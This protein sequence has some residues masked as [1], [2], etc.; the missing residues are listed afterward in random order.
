MADRFG[1]W[2]RPKKR[3]H[4]NEEL[5]E[6][7]TDRELAEMPRVGPQLEV[8]PLNEPFS[9]EIQEN[10]NFTGLSQSATLTNHENFGRYIESVNTITPGEKIVE[11]EAFVSVNDMT[12][13][14][15]CLTCHSLAATTNFIGCDNCPSIAFCSQKCKTHNQTHEYECRTLFHSTT[16]G[17]D[18]NI[19]CAIQMIFEFLVIFSNDVDL[20]MSTVEEVIN[21]AFRNGSNNEDG[22]INLNATPESINDDLSKFYCILN[23]KQNQYPEE[24]AF[25]AFSMIMQ[26]PRI[27][28]LFTGDGRKCF[29]QRLLMHNLAVIHE[30]GFN[31]ELIE[32]VPRKTLFDIVSFF[33]HS[34]TP[35]MLIFSEGKKIFG[36]A[37]RDIETGTQL[38][39]SYKHFFD[40]ASETEERRTILRDLWGFEC[41]C[42][43]CRWADRNGEEITPTQIK[44]AQSRIKQKLEEGG[45]DWSLQIGA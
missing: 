19:K 11:V 29:L 26:F 2:C 38:C 7:S 37:S 10:S 5:V 34:C 45:Y 30:N 12:D 6:Q 44:Q 23:L 15:Y 42:E 21:N 18:I 35:H 40:T 24:D 31:T 22:V 27:K 28:S 43:R 20:L 1:F 25:D 4:F 16:F 3:R 14:A 8:K 9:A 33:N 17:A 32:N 41:N 36:I 13:I 39:I